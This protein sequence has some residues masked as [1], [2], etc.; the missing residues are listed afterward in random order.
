MIFPPPAC[1][2]GRGWVS[3][4]PSEDCERIG[5]FVPTACGRVLP[6][7]NSPFAIAQPPPIPEAMGN[8]GPL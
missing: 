4:T 7:T 6:Q 3:L 5:T 2:R 1:G 8:M